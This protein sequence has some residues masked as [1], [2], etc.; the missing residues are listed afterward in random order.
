MSLAKSEV[1]DSDFIRTGNKK[2]SKN[3]GKKTIIKAVDQLGTPT[4]LWL[5]VRRHKV[6]LLALGNIVLVMNFV[7]P[8]WFDMVIGLV[9]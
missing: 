7:L 8:E 1:A 5:I 3:I 9:K 4:L 6:G 2:P